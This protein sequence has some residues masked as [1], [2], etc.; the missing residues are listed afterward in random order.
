MRRRDNS[1]FRPHLVWCGAR[2]TSVRIEPEFWFWFRQIA[3]EQGYPVK[4]LIEAI[5]KAKHPH[6][7]LSST[8]RVYV[9]QYLHDHPKVPRKPPR[10]VPLKTDRQHRR[11]GLFGHQTSLRLEAAYWD[12]IQDIRRKTGLSLRELVEEVVRHKSPKRSLT[13]ALR[14]AIAGSYHPNP[15]QHEQWHR[16]GRIVPGRD[17]KT[18][19][20]LALFGPYV[21]VSKTRAAR[22]QARS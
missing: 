17:D 22:A 18:V 5:E 16:L 4:A 1:R 13:S 6:T 7:S 12:G 19:Y 3:A 2:P 10:S 9:T 8:L 15:L 21:R 11:M 20:G 14:V